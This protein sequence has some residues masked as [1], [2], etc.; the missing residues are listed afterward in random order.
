MRHILKLQV[1]MNLNFR[2]ILYFLPVRGSLEQADAIVQYEL[3]ILHYFG[4]QAFGKLVIVV[5]NS[6]ELSLRPSGDEFSCTNIIETKRNFNKCLMLS[7]LYKNEA[8]IPEIPIICISLSET[9][10][11]ILEK[12]RSA[13]V[14]GPDIRPQFD[15]RTCKS[16]HQKVGFIK[17]EKMVCFI[18]E[19]DMVPYEESKCHPKLKHSMF[20][21]VLN[22]VK[23]WFEPS[24]C[25]HCGHITYSVGCLEVGSEIRYMGELI[26]CDHIV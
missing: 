4:K 19:T 18:N 10:E 5:T 11:S 8:D 12:V 1:R 20:T 9:C 6:K 25:I 15:L 26:T 24:P 23:R 14:T 2:K 3:K 17:N 22:D 13:I 21:K 16:C 7:G